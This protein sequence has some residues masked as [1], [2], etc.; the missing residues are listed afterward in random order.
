MNR[1]LFDRKLEKGFE[2][3]SIRLSLNMTQNH[4]ADIHIFIHVHIHTF[5]PNYVKMI[6]NLKS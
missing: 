6:K 5:F 3:K 2:Y 4:Y 1:Y